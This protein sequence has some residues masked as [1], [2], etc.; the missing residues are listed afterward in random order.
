MPPQHA[1]RSRCRE[2][3]A[4]EPVRIEGLPH[5]LFPTSGRPSASR[6]RRCSTCDCGVAGGAAAPL[7]AAQ[8]LDEIRLRSRLD[9]PRGCATSW[10]VRRCASRVISRHIAAVERYLD[11][12]MSTSIPCVPT[13]AQPRAVL[14]TPLRGTREKRAPLSSAPSP[15]RAPRIADSARWGRLSAGCSQHAQTFRMP[16]GSRHAQ[17]AP[18]S[19]ADYPR[20]WRAVYA[21]SLLGGVLSSAAADRVA[22][23]SPCRW[24]A[25]CAT[26]QTVFLAGRDAGL[27][28]AVCER[29][30]RPEGLSGTTCRR[31]VLPSSR[32]FQPS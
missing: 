31:R 21:A 8:R 17:L 7:A 9:T 23:G 11:T 16:N 3:N 30:E 18:P 12:V 28:L 27:T 5:G 6:A 1:S 24:A 14:H 22:S 25:R 15:S 19:A 32:R 2:R 10:L 4:H 26:P 29:A 13:T 20:C